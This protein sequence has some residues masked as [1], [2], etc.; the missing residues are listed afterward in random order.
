MDVAFLML[1]CA[2]AAVLWW[3]AGRR[4][5]QAEVMLRLTEQEGAELEE[6][7]SEQRKLAGAVSR[8]I[9]SAQL[10]STRAAD[11]ERRAELALARVEALSKV[12]V[13]AADLVHWDQRRDS[14]ELVN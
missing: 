14:G 1:L 8:Q 2:V 12:A 4:Y 9:A 10:L 11:R 3:L 5:G 13:D 7:L 6:R